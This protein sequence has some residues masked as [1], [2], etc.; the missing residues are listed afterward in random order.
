MLLEIKKLNIKN[1]GYKRNITLEKMYINTSSIVSIINYEGAK[2]FLMR[3]NSNFSQEKF[4][5]IKLNEGNKVQEI[6]AFGTAE[7]LFASFSKVRPGKIL[8]ND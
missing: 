8:L 5:L 4:S 2:P 1:E 6:I 3:E 7:E